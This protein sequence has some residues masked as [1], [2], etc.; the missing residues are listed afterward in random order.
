MLDRFRWDLEQAGVGRSQ[1]R[2]TL[3]VLQG[4]FRYAEERGRVL[5]NPVKL[6]RKPSGRRQR[7]I[8]VLAPEQVEAVRGRL[9]EDGRA[10]DATLVSVLAYAGL[11]PQEVLALEWSHVRERTLLIDQKNVGS[12]IVPGQKTRRPPRT[13]DLLSPLRGDL[14]EWRLRSGNPEGGLVFPT[15]GGTP[16]REHDWLNWNRRVWTP[17]ARALGIREPPYT[18]RHSY[19]SLRIREGASIPEVAEEP[20]HSPQMTLNTYSH[21]IRELRGADRVSAEDEV[22]AARSVGRGAASAE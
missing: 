12:E 19:A 18:L 9:L 14:L 2:Q 1:I 4:M 11:R 10:G 17:A 6:I 5:R 13:V 7:A 16:L 3:A 8:V 21:V 20:G 15:P 22:A